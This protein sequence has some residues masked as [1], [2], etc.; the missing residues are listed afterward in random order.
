MRMVVTGFLSDTH[1]LSL[2]LHC[3]VVYATYSQF[4]IMSRTKHTHVPTN[5]MHTETLTHKHTDLEIEAC[6]N[7]PLHLAYYSI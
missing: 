1:S 3:I 6:E 2:S 4:I 5:H 7:D